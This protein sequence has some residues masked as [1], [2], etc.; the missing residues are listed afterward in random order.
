MF[1][2]NALLSMK[3]GKAAGPNPWDAP[4][5]EWA[6]TSPPPVYNFPHIPV[7]SSRTPLWE[8]RGDLPVMTGLRVDDRE[9]LLTTVIDARP[10]LREP[11]PL[12]TIWPLVAGLALAALFISS[13]FTPWAVVIGTLPLAAAL[14][15]WFWP[16]S[17]DV[18]PEPVIE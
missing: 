16:K 9:Q 1:V 17:P 13:I 2:A 12:P 4:G 5:L 6:T 15:A 7:V 10:D 18:T 14:I 11:S 8:N 3:R